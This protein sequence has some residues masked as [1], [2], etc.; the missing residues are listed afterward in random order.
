MEKKHILICGRPHVGKT[1]LIHKL[2]A[3]Y[4][5]RI[6]GYTTKLGMKENHWKYFYLYP[7]D[8]TEYIP[9]EANCIGWG[10]GKERHTNREIFEGLGIPYLKENVGDLILMDE[11]GFME[12]G[13]PDFCQAILD[14]LDGDTPVLAAVKD[15]PGVEFLDAVRNHPNAQIYWITKEN[16]D[17]LY[18]EVKA[19]F[20]EMM[21]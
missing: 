6:S 1:T 7:A 10:N 12:T 21:G 18:E 13:A 20:A 5:G 8:A 3:D 14:C 11:I 4:T 16:R 2:L 15:K 9:S 17:E 19:A